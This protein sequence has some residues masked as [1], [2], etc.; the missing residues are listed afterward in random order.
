MNACTKCGRRHT[1]AEEI[2]GNRLSCTEVKQYWVTITREHEKSYGHLAQVTNDVSGNWI[3][4]K[5]KRVLPG[6]KFS[7]VEPNG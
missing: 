2:K 4:Y 1:D 3:C 5:C 6:D 7:S